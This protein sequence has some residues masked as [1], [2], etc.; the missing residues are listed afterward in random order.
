MSV[1]GQRIHDRREQIGLTQEQ[2]GELIGKDQ[3]QIWRYEAGKQTP[4]AETLVQLA[5]ALETSTDYLVGESDV[6]KPIGSVDDLDELEVEMLELL[7]SQNPG[8]R[9]KIM[10]A[11]KALV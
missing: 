3:K 10:R 7:R 1:L 9:E 4:S 6:L 5:R 11:I 8:Q 2:L